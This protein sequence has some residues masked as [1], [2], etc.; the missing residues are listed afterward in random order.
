MHPRDCEPGD[1][2]A[3][4]AYHALYHGSRGVIWAL[5]HLQALGAAC[6]HIDYRSFTEGLQHALQ[7]KDETLDALDRLI[8]SHQ[9][10]PARA[11]MWGVPGTLLAARCL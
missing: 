5:Q 1:D 7:P 9:D 2:P 11:L 3:L 6:L 10:H 8:G 4:Q